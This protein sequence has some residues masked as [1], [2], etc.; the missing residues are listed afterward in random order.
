VQAVYQR[1]GQLLASP[2]PHHKED[3]PPASW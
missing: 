1:F 2:L 3:D